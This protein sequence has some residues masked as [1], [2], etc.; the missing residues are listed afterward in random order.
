MTAW[1]CWPAGHDPP[2]SGYAVVPHVGGS[3]GVWLP[4]SARHRSAAASI[5]DAS[6]VRTHPPFLFAF[7]TAPSNFSSAAASQSLSTGTLLAAAFWKHFI[8]AAT[9]WIAAVCFAAA[10]LALG[11]TAACS[12]AVTAIP[13]SIKREI[14]AG[15]MGHLRRSI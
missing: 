9:F 8:L 15:D 3:A 6:P 12:G 10:H 2:H 7:A 11:E 14:E 5:A 4:M 1:H 13:V